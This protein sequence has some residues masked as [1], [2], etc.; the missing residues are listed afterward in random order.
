MILPIE[1]SIGGCTVSSVSHRFSSSRS[2]G[3]FEN[4]IWYK[5]FQRNFCYL[6]M[7]YLPDRLYSVQGNCIHRSPAAHEHQFA[8]PLTAVSHVR[9]DPGQGLGYL[10]LD[11]TTLGGSFDT[12]LFFLEMFRIFQRTKFCERK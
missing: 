3:P 4:V 1:A 11:P 12:N 7:G 5:K 9:V 6:H 2:H 8:V 10:P